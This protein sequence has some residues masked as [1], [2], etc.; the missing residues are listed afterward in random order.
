MK[1]SN[2][3]KHIEH[4]GR[5][6]YVTDVTMT[7]DEYIR[8][9]MKVTEKSRRMI[10][11]IAEIIW[12]VFGIV[13]FVM[14]QYSVTVFLGVTIIAYPLLIDYFYKRK[15]KKTFDAMPAG[16]NEHLRY[17]FYPDHVLL[18]TNHGEGSYKYSDF[19]KMLE[20]KEEII[21]LLSSNQGLLV[22]KQNCSQE[23]LE[24]L[25]AKFPASG[26]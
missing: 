11:I 25:R 16:Q 1:K 15:L 8:M 20:T 2:P 4:P 13:A 26:K 5:P 19:V 22:L 9:A 7:I 24:F 10:V 6:T 18:L 23:L 21:L 17:E 14:K 3:A 12:I